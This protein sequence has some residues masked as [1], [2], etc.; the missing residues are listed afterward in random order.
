L[1]F[2]FPKEAARLVAG[3]LDKLDVGKDQELD[4]FMG[5]CVAN[6]VRA[7]DFIKSVAWSKDPA[8]RAALVGIFKRAD[9]VDSLLAALPAVEERELIRDRLAPLLAAL[10]ADEGRP[11]GQGFHLLVALSQ[12]T[13]DMAQSVFERYLRSASAQ[14]CHTVC[15]V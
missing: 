1:L 6:G 10:P 12:R 9:D 4:N 8:V 3:R 7:D 15:L 2:Y 11:S 13:P 5:R 14:R